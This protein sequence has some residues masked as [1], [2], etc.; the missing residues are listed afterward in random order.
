MFKKNE[1][2]KIE[3]NPENEVMI[4]KNNILTDDGKV[5]IS[6]YLADKFISENK[7]LQILSYMEQ[8]IKQQV[9]KQILFTLKLRG[10]IE[11]ELN[12]FDREYQ[13]SAKGEKLILE[14]GITDLEDMRDKIDEILQ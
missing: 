14:Q 13:I 12:D 6:L 1:E 3:K 11:L 4:F 7:I 8:D 10:L 2:H 5:L 9:V